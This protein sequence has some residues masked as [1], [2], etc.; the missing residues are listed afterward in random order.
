M[1]DLPEKK[2]YYM[3]AVRDKTILA[4]FAKTEVSRSKSNFQ[5][6]TNEILAK[7]GRGTFVLPY[8]E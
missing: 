2:L 1:S 6:F 8:Q 4:D 3:C 5:Q 7:I